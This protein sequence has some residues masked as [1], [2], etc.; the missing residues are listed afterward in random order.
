MNI[1]LWNATLNMKLKPPSHCFN[2][3]IIDSLIQLI[4]LK[5]LIHSGM[6]QVTFWF[7]NRILEYYYSHYFCH[8][9]VPT[10]SIVS[11][12]ITWC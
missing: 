8:E 9:T 12:I 11:K 10:D 1:E 5:R 4:H 3:W 6:K 7:Q 2:E